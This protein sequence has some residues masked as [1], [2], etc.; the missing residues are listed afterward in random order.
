MADGFEDGDRAE[1]PPPEDQQFEDDD[2]TVYVWD[3]KLRKFQPKHAAAADAARPD[4]DLEEMTFEAEEET[5][6]AFVPP[7]EVWN[8]PCPNPAS[9]AS[10]SLLLSAT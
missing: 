9:V 1:T 5:I 10:V 7:V 8:L 2:G 4:Y 3:R 6:P